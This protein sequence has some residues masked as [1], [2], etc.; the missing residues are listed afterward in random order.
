MIK[1]KNISAK[2][3]HKETLRE[4]KLKKLERK[5]KSNIAK[6]KKS[7]NING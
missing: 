5:L 4:L 6:R 1:K 2:S 3:L 7:K